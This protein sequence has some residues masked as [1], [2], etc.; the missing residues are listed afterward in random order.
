[1]KNLPTMFM[2]AGKKTSH[3]KRIQMTKMLNSKKAKNISGLRTKV[4]HR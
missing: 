2:V 1:M 4:F 3:N